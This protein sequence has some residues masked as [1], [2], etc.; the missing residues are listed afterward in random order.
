MR[1]IYVAR[2]FRVLFI[3]LTLTFGISLTKVQGSEPLASDVTLPAHSNKDMV[4]ASGG[5]SVPGLERPVMGAT[6]PPS[7][8]S[9]KVMAGLLVLHRENNDK[10]TLFTD[11][12]GTELL[13]ARDLNL[14]IGFG[15]DAG[16]GVKLCALRTAFG[17]EVRYFGIHE[18][19][20]S[21]SAISTSGVLS[22]NGLSVS[23]FGT[24]ANPVGVTAKYESALQNVELNLGWY[25]VERIRVFVG[26]RYINIDE[27]LKN[28]IDFIPGLVPTTEKI[29]AKNNLL[30]GQLGVN[31]V[32]L[33]NTDDGFS[34]DGWAKV[35]YFN[36]DIST[37]AKL[38]PSAP[39]AFRSSSSKDKGALATEFGIG[40][41]YAFSRNIALSARYQ[42]LWL[43]EVAF[44]PQ[45]A[46]VVNYLNGRF[47]AETDSV[48]YQGGWIGFL[49]SW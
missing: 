30:G 18:W 12:A 35:G 8:L 10:V 25:P 28:G 23:Y 9:W 43:D 1:V 17:A 32:F 13:N 40:V 49:L 29:T 42:L 20:E 38:K 22:R 36:N 6:Q 45:Q 31:G 2:F 39:F 4:A 27:E 7:P 26:G 15:L 48:L 41:Q 21:D 37:R 24:P 11:S 3:C 46:T 34:I 44:A 33:G 16:L 5:G 47:S 19:S 14:G